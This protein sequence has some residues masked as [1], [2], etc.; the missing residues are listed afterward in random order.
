MERAIS[1]MGTLL[2]RPDKLI[3]FDRKQCQNVTCGTKTVLT[4]HVIEIDVSA[5]E[6]LQ[7]LCQ[8]LPD[9]VQRCA[10]CHARGHEFCGNHCRDSE[11][12]KGTSTGAVHLH[13]KFLAPKLGEGAADER[14]VEMRDTI[15]RLVLIDPWG[16]RGGSEEG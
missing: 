9:A 3:T 4:V 14:F 6:S 5:S 10:I 2:H 12:K 8:L 16:K 15:G 7:R 1:S 13:T 11:S